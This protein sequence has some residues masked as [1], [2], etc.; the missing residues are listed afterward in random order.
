M[1]PSMSEKQILL[2]RLIALKRL[3]KV[4]AAPYGTPM[5]TEI[6]AWA[7]ELEEYIKRKDRDERC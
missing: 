1:T 7:A 5:N 4:G 2:Q 3:A 6:D